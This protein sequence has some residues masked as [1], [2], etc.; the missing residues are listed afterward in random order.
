MPDPGPNR[1]AAVPSARAFLRVA[2]PVAV[3]A[4]VSFGFRLADEPHFVDESAMISQSY[5]ADLLIDGDRDDPAWL[6]FPGYDSSPLPK[7]LIGLAFRSVGYR[8]PGPAAAHR[9]FL[10]TSTRFDDPPGMLA[11]AR[12]PFAIGGSFGCVALYA[13]GVLARDR[14]TG[15]LAAF[16]LMVNP[17]YRMHARRA[18]ADVFVEAFL[19]A[20][21]AS[22]LW[23]WRRRLDG[24]NGPVI[25]IATCLS[26]VCAAFA[27]LAKLNGLLTLVIVA[28][29]AC[30]TLI[31]PGFPI[32]RRIA[33]AT[34]SIVAGAVAA[35][36][37]I[38]FNPF[39]TADP[40]GPL[41][42][43]LAAIAR[44]GAVSRA[45]LLIVHRTET[46]RDQ[47]R[48]FA[49]NALTTPLEKAE[50]AAVQG[51]GRFG[52]FGPRHS[53]STRRFDWSQDRGAV[54]WLPWVGAGLAWAL[55]RGRRQWATGAPPTGWA[56]AVHAS[57]AAFVVTAYLPLAWDRYLLPLQPGS[58]LLAAG[59]AASS[60]DRLANVLLGRDKSG[61]A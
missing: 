43:P 30:L 54:L 9:W 13:L 56:I 22:L 39:L 36:T 41:P 55:A 3:V 53:D 57:V 19:L 2:L 10:D 1:G 28:A 8:R 24:R 46:A 34:D 17:L 44:M 25:W 48:I 45:R 11:V 23:A 15:L 16:L 20:S 33:F 26:G 12:W 50:V 18:M 14:K 31:L 35:V 7:Y 29:W 61:G 42:P 52:P 59:V 32:R 6:E 4:V 40:A 47:I 58:A 21:L 37:F 49:H 51:F 60:A 27:A 38:A 5:F